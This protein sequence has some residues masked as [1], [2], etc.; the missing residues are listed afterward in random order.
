M[1][2]ALL[3]SGG[4]DSIAI[5]WWLRPEFLITVNY[6]QKPAKAEIRAAS[7]VAETLNL[8]HEVIQCDVSA[9]GSGDLANTA[10]V[11]IA[12]VREWWP[13]RNQFLITVSAMRAVV[14]GV[15]KLVIGTLRTD[16]VHRDG[17]P[18]FIAAMS[19]ALSQQEGEMTLEAPAIN[20]DGPELIRR[21]GVP[22]EVLAWAHSCHTSDYACGECRGCQKHYETLESLGLPPY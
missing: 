22:L 18:G 3:L 6:G 15:D 11:A 17:S 1:T 19:Y 2:R 10:P 5:A 14:L 20:F 21:S 12:P 4:M 8:P 16:A 13:F 9:L 7:A